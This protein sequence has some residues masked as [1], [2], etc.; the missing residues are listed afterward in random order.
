MH[1][2]K[3]ER[4]DGREATIEKRELKKRKKGKG[5]HSDTSEYPRFCP[6]EST[7]PL[8]CLVAIAS[9]QLFFLQKH[10]ICSES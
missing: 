4:D 3:Q 1:P 9:S 10:F 7:R 6:A 2:C 8:K 5:R